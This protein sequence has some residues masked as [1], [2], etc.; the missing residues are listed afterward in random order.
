MQFTTVPELPPL[1][2]PEAVAKTDKSVTL[3]LKTDQLDKKF[4][5]QVGHSEHG[6]VYYSWTDSEAFSGSMHP[7]KGLTPNTNYVFRARVVDEAT[8][9]CSEWSPLTAYVRTFT[10]EED[11]KR[12]GTYFEHALKLERE[13]KSILQ[14]QIS[15]LTV[16]LD[17]TARVKTEEHKST[18]KIHEDMLSSRRIID[19]TVSKLRSELTMQAA[20]LQSVKSQRAADEQMIQDLLNEQENLRRA[21]LQQKDQ[22]KYEH[23][24]QQLRAQLEKNEQALHK[25]QEQVVASHDQIA[26]YE[27]SLTQTQEEIKQ[28]EDEVE[29]IMNDC[30]RMVQEQADLAAVKQLEIEDALMEAKTSLEQQ[31]DINTYL[32]DEVSRLRE[33]NHHLKNQIQEMDSE[34]APKL[35]RLEDE[36]EELRR[37]LAAYRR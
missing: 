6:Y 21:Q 16:M 29:R 3:R 5:C 8:K 18:A 12:A 26:K 25:H 9:Q 30:N 19:T 31:L 37:Q 10:E 4:K 28:K 11:A 32:R 13:Q 14:K 2:T 23:E 17:D 34:I 1:P 7:V 15:K 33:E 35:F 22:A 20:A 24:M 36:N 27:A